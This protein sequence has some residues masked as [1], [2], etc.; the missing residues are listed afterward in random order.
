MYRWSSNMTFVVLVAACASATP[1]P[2]TRSSGPPAAVVTTSTG[3]MVRLDPE[4]AGITVPLDAS[5][6]RVWTVLLEVYQALG[7]PAEINDATTWSYG[8][9]RFSQSR[10]AGRRVAEFV[11]CGHEGAG[12]SAMSAHRIRLSIVSSLKPARGGK[13]VLQTEVGGS[14]TSIEGT[15]TAP[16]RCVSEGQLEQQIHAQVIQRLGT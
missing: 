4:M 15:S 2:G 8:T 1:A 13:T 16:V 7:V 5:P 10:L 14:A 11:R 12:A 3:A 9:R 6:D